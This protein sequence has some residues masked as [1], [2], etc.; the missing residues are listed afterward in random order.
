[1]GYNSAIAIPKFGHKG[2]ERFFLRGTTV[3]IQAKHARRLRLILG[4][5]NV[6]R[7]P[8]DMAL[9]GLDLHPLKGERKGAWAFGVS[10]NWRITFAFSGPDV[11]NVDYEDY[12]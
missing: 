10:G 1:M 4:R 11:V 9:P 3:G 6:A 8:R 7:E 12:H 2:L 5:L